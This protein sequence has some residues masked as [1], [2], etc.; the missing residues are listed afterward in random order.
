MKTLSRRNWLATTGVAGVGF[1]ALPRWLAAAELTREMILIPAGTFQMGTTAEQAAQLAAQ[2]RCHVSW[3]GGEVPP[4]SLTLAAFEMD[5]FPV[6]NAQ[7]FQFCKATGGSFPGHWIGQ[8]P[9]IQILEQPVTYVSRAEARA[10]AKWAGKKLPTEAQWE[11]AARGTD[12][13][14]YP[15]GNEFDP[16]ACRWHRDI[17]QTA[18]GVAAVAAH[19]RGASPYDVQGMAGN[20]AEWCEDGPA[21]DTAFT[22]GGCWNTATPLNLRSAARGLSGNAAN[23]LAFVGFRCVREVQS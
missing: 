12:G 16:A 1:F 6:T 20:V 21:G 14:L 3:L 7:Y 2:F 15:W 5:K 13:R 9:V 10:Y 4:R 17:S 22:K 19:P 11:K 18:L 23:Q 8:P